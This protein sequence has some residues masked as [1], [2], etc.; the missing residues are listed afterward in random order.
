MWT[1][2]AVQDFAHVYAG[3][4]NEQYTK[5]AYKGKRMHQK[6]EQFK[7][8]YASIH[9]TQSNVQEAVEVSDS[10]K[11]ITVTINL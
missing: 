1:D 7:A 2:S 8:D 9:G 11:S 6:I 4:Y 5:E 3:L 10:G